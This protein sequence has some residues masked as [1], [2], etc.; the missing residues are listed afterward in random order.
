[1]QQKTWEPERIIDIHAHVLPGVDDGSGSM[2]ETLQMLQ[3][4]QEEGITDI[5]AT[6]HYQSGRFY[7][8][9]DMI[10]EILLEVQDRADE[11]GIGIRLYPGTEIYYRSDLEERLEKGQLATMNGGDRILVE[12]GP[13]EEFSYI[14]NAMEEL[15]GMGYVPILAHVERFGCMLEK[16]S[17][18]GELRSMGCEIQ[19]NAGS[20][21]GKYGHRIKKYLQGLLAEEMIDYVGTDAHDTAGRAPYIKKCTDLLYKKYDADY[22]EA[23]LYRN[24]EKN[25]L[26]KEEL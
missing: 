17:R 23:I 11:A 1:M 4:A 5:I 7:T 12:F 3:T 14:R 18:V 9:A 15:R 8:P 21:S 2:E 22:V 6:P 26:E 19:S 25:L 13:M 20:I 16:A 10:R 24:A